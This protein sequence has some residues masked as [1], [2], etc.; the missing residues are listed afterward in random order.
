MDTLSVQRQLISTQLAELLGPNRCEQGDFDQLTILGQGAH[1]TTWVVRRKHDS[2]LLCCKRI[3][4]ERFPQGRETQLLREVEILMMLD[5]HPHVIGFIGA[6]LA[7]DGLSIVQEY[8]EGGTLQHRL[9][10]RREIGEPLLETEILD[11]F[12]QLVSALQHIHSHGV[13]HRDLK[14]SN[15]FFDRRNLARLGDFGIAAL[16]KYA[17]PPFTS[18]SLAVLGAAGG[19]HH[20][21]QLTVLG[22]GNA[23]SI[24]LHCAYRS[25]LPA[26]A[27]TP[28]GATAMVGKVVRFSGR[29]CT[30]PQS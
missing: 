25:A 16:T 1:S 19:A 5:G 29:L 27:P 10:L 17:R 22:G 21:H 18:R 11:T 23:L 4:S 13:L 30:S 7:D 8:A 3:P 14:P 2:H 9:D 15:V 12:V 28:S 20:A 24:A 26:H 6:F